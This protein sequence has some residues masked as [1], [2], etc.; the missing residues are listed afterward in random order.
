MGEPMEQTKRVFPVGCNRGFT[1]VELLVVIAIIALLMGILM[2]VLNKA[3]GQAQTVV[4]ASNLK[5]YGPA[6]V[7]YAG[8]NGDKTPYS[9]SWLYSKKTIDKREKSGECREVCRWHYDKDAP[10]GT[11][12]PYL[13]N[14]NVH[15]CPTFKN[16]AVAGGLNICPSKALHPTKKGAMPFKPRYSYSMN[17]WLGFDWMS[18]IADVQL[19]YRTEASIRLS[20]V[21]R[22]S[23]CFAFSE[24][25]LWCINGGQDALNHPLRK[26][27]TE[28][29]SNSAL[30]KTDLWMYAL[31]N[32]N[33]VAN[34][35]TYHGVSAGKRDEGRANVLFVDGHVAT[36]R[37]LAG[38]DAYLEYGRPFNGH[39]RQNRGQI[40]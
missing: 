25:N 3:R 9:F 13:K 26:G 32:G 33:V 29:Y 6:L 10:D 30:A 2:P 39:E 24:E 35:A 34:F 17:R 4:C 16:F 37:G 8:D 19:S 15:M 1:L 11:L 18:F 5:N 20:Q 7:M 27:D 31:D 36:I 28:A 40:W 22:A 23:Q 38:R 14:I 12:W 21:T